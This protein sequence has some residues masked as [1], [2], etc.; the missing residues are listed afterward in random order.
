[1]SLCRAVRGRVTLIRQVARSGRLPITPTSRIAHGVAPWQSA[2]GGRVTV[3]RCPAWPCLVPCL[4]SCL[5]PCLGPCLAV[6]LVLRRARPM[7]V[8]RASSAFTL[9]QP[10]A[11]AQPAGPRRQTMEHMHGRAPTRCRFDSAHGPRRFLSALP[12]RDTRD[13]TVPAHRRRQ[14][15][16][17][18][19]VEQREP[20]GPWIVALHRKR[21]TRNHARQSYPSSPGTPFSW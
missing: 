11:I 16:P 7:H 17:R 21:S 19:L 2:F 15:H 4:V 6:V 14:S 8:T 1:V 12:P 13:K 5:V 18:C 20:Q 9:L 10:R 3:P